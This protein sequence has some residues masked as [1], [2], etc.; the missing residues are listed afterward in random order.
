MH[1]HDEIEQALAALADHVADALAAD[2]WRRPRLGDGWIAVFTRPIPTGVSAVV[3]LGRAG[4]PLVA[5]IGEQRVGTVRTDDTPGWDNA[6]RAAAL[7]DE[8]PF[9]PGA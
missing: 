4:D 7:F 1:S 6:F 8:D 9:V 2:G 5:H 3:E